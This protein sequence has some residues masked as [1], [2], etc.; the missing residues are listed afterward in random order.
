[1]PMLEEDC[2]FD[3]PILLT[4]PANDS[5]NDCA[6]SSTARKY[7]YLTSA[8]YEYR[9]SERA[10]VSDLKDVVLET[11]HEES[12]RPGFQSHADMVKA[13]QVVDE[14]YLGKYAFRLNSR[15]LLARVKKPENV[16]AVLTLVPHPTQ[17]LYVMQEVNESNAQ[18]SRENIADIARRRVLPSIGATAAH[19]LESQTAGCTDAIYNY[20]PL[21]LASPPITIY[22]PVF[23]KFL[24]MM[25]EP[26][27]FTHEELDYAR[28]FVS[29][30]AAYHRY[31]CDRPRNQYMIG[32]AADPTIF[33]RTRLSCAASGEFVADGIVT[34]AEAHN[35]FPTVAA[36]TEM[37]L[38]VGEGGCDPLAKAECDY[39]AIYCS[40]EVRIAAG[41]GIPTL[42]PRP[43]AA[44][45]TG[46][47]LSRVPY[48]HGGP[49]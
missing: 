41:S 23:A 15:L 42:T 10:H 32:P 29:Q 16:V 11:V 44:R 5:V 26:H 47:L 17:L 34:T 13:Y 36:I 12:L 6:A 21:E 49:E 40:E 2:A 28:A 46:M 19:G 31:D 43:G 37:T 3:I 22:H 7:Q 35:D 8:W 48:R 30:A 27:E 4:S 33:M 45:A 38:E 39:A 24:Q 20:R 9:R 25:A 18:I 14:A 1:M